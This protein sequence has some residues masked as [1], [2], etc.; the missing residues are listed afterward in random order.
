MSNSSPQ[1]ST[2]PKEQQARLL[3]TFAERLFK[4]LPAGLSAQMPERE[5]LTVAQQAFEFF[6]TRPEPVKVCVITQVIG[7]APVT[8]I[9]SAM[10]DC[11]FIVDS[12]RGYLHELELGG[13]VLLHPIF[14]VARDAQGRLISFEEGSARERRESLVTV[15]FETRLDDAT[16]SRVAAEVEHRMHEVIAATSD[17]EKMTAR[18][19]RICE[20]LVP[21][22][23][24]VELRDF[25]R[26]LV[27]GSFLFLGYE[28][29]T[30]SQLDGTPAL[31]REAGS[32]LGILRDQAPGEKPAR[33]F[34]TIESLDPDLLFQGPVLIV[35]KS[36]VQSHV[37]RL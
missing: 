8:V 30:V 3:P 2:R 11:A 10:A 22:R 23:E 34:H 15:I 5:R 16:A 26:W 28:R 1:P 6:F 24:L 25:L 32:G 37:Q 12:W 31:V 18:A 35:S 9:E 27:A 14:S 17:F 19:L 29:Y 13:F 36:N 7:G 4:R 21:L 20:E 33:T